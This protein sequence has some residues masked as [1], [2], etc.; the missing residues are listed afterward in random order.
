MPLLADE[1]PAPDTYCS[2]TRRSFVTGRF[3][4]HIS[5]FQADICSNWTPLNMTL[6][7]QKLALAGFQ[8]HFVGKT[9]LGFATTDHLPVNRG[10]TS[11][12]GYM[13]GMEDYHYGRL[14]CAYRSGGPGGK[15]MCPPGSD[16]GT[17][18]PSPPIAALNAT[19]LPEPDADSGQ[20]PSCQPYSPHCIPNHVTPPP[21][22]HLIALSP[23]LLLSC[24]NERL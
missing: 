17:L 13:Y 14:S 18:P 8:S 2:P 20:P 3:P 10:F 16:P 7:S 6:L 24:P 4:V 9:N 11:H 19:Q 23:P 12:L 15:P 1:P 22:P 5:G 21:S